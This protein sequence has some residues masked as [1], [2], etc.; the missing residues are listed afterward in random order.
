MSGTHTHSAIPVYYE[1]RGYTTPA[2]GV[3]IQIK[4]TS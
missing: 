4:V 2:A 3:W 1:G